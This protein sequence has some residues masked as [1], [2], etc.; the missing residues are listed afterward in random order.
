M[1]DIKQSTV[2]S[3]Q[4][5]VEQKMP[6]TENAS[7]R[8]HGSQYTFLVTLLSILLLISVLIAGFFAYQ[9]QRLVAELR[10]KIQTPVAT[11]VPSPIS[12]ETPVATSSATPTS[13]NT[14]CTMEAKICPDG[15]AVGRSGSKCEFSPCPTPKP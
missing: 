6:T 7:V 14:A 8:E 10:M 4:S 9:T 2:N 13:T 12:S 1:E 5:T 3:E 11:F 15:S